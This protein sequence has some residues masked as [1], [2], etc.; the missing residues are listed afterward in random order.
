MGLDDD[1]KHNAEDVKGKVKETV[2][3]ATDNER[4]QAEGVADQASAKI[5]KAGD[6]IKDAFTDDR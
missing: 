4:L 3:D 1:I 2:G 5:K 6:D